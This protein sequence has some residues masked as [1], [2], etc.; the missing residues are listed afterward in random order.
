MMFGGGPILDP[1]MVPALKEGLAGLDRAF[2]PDDSGRYLNFTEVAHD[3]ED[4]F[5]KGTVPRLRDVKN[6]Y[7][8]EG[9]FRANH[10]V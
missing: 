4:M 9:L 3:V 1:A 6:T 8:P 2:A 7:D 10:A 5:P